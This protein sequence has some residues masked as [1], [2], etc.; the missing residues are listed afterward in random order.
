MVRIYT[1]LIA[2]ALVWAGGLQAQP[3][4]VSELCENSLV[5]LLSPAQRVELTRKLGSSGTDYDSLFD[6]YLADQAARNEKLSAYV[7]EIL[8]QFSS[9]WLQG[10]KGTERA[11]LFYRL[12]YNPIDVVWLSKALPED[13]REEFRQ[14][15]QQTIQQRFQSLKAAPGLHRAEH[16]FVRLVSVTPLIWIPE[17]VLSYMKATWLTLGKYRPKVMRS[18][19]AVETGTEDAGDC[20][21]MTKGHFTTLELDSCM[22]ST[23]VR[24]DFLEG[25]P[26][27]TTLIRVRGVL[28]GALKQTGSASMIA[29]RNIT[30]SEGRLVL[31]MG[32]V[33]EMDSDQASRALVEYE[34]DKRNWPVL[35]LSRLKVKAHSFLFNS[36]A[37]EPS[38]LPSI[39]AI[40]AA[41]FSRRELLEIISMMSEEGEPTESQL[42][43]LHPIVWKNFLRLLNNKYGELKDEP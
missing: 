30:D 9:Q 13:R 39:A 12:S 10:P 34:I 20:I 8:T 36:N 25:Y 35:R 26:K 11:I 18:I 40:G 23:K 21:L 29:L 38:A 32:G 17:E 14:A 42:E 6:I 5:S 31:A 37:Y 41:D 4:A 16:Y 22:E 24:K 15:V 33:Y 2:I 3:V 27:E 19:T 28:V 7:Q 1:S 43:L